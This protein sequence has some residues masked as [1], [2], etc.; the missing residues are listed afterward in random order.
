MTN[1]SN[2]NNNLFS[3]ALAVSSL[4]TT[5]LIT[6]ADFNTT[7]VN[8][9]EAGRPASWAAHVEA[10]RVICNKAAN[11]YWKAVL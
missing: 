8:W 11:R 6:A 5:R 1:L 7:F 3:V 9:C 2:L 10:M 4:N